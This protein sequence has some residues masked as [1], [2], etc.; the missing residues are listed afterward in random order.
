MKL[1]HTFQSRLQSLDIGLFDKVDSQSSDDDKKSLL[2]LQWAVHDRVG[3]YCYLEIGSHL[4]GSLQTHV[5]DPK[6]RK[7]YSIDPRPL[8][9]SDKRE[10]EF[11]YENNSTARMLGNLQ[12]LADDLMSRIVC[13]DSDATKVPLS[14]IV[15]KPHLCFIDGEHTD[16][17]VLSDFKFCLSIAHPDSVIAFHDAGLLAVGLNKIELELESKGIPFKGV[18]LCGEVYAIGL[19]NTRILDHPVIRNRS[20]S[21]RGFLL[22]RRIIMALKKLVPKSSLPL[23]QQ[24]RKSFGL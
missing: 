21:G 22:K 1:D 13:F 7:I 15:E 12:P 8:I 5:L 16:K 9:V 23:F 24:L 18:K 14:S 2:A 4:G 6:C 11:V 19:G 3:E 10:G 17:A 20:S